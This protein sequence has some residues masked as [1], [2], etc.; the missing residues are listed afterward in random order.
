MYA[1]KSLPLPV[2]MYDGVKEP[3][4]PPGRRKIVTSNADVAVCYL[5]GPEQQPLFGRHIL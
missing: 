3:P 1:N 2:F 5:L 4:I